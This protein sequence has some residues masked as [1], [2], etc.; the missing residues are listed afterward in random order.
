M[1]SEL[2]LSQYSACYLVTA[3]FAALLCTSR[4]LQAISRKKESKPC[5]SVAS[6]GPTILTDRA[7]WGP[8]RCTSLQR[9]GPHGGPV[10]KHKVTL[11]EN[12]VKD[13]LI[14]KSLP[15]F[16]EGLRVHCLTKGASVWPATELSETQLATFPKWWTSCTLQKRQFS[17]KS[18]SF[19]FAG[20]KGILFDCSD[21]KSRAV[22]HS[23][24]HCH[25]SRS[26]GAPFMVSSVLHSQQRVVRELPISSAVELK[27]SSDKPLAQLCTLRRSQLLRW[28]AWNINLIYALVLTQDFF[29]A[30]FHSL[31]LVE[32]TCRLVFNC[33][34]SWRGLKWIICLIGYT[35]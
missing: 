22:L 1:M 15:C 16:S 18:N 17:K 13:G 19:G 28:Y 21:F 10:R 5:P 29:F 34:N 25:V 9:H 26:W 33:C 4:P 31:A 14:H 8:L 20:W 30:L 32:V 3:S 6:Q 11:Q 35:I 12:T 23:N 27:F 24:F 7:S 2:F